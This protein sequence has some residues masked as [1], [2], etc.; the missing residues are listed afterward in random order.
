MRWYRKTV[1]P[2]QRPALSRGAIDH[3]GA[4]GSSAWFGGNSLRLFTRQPLVR[5]SGTNVPA[6]T[7]L[8]NSMSA[9]M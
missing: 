2:Y 7:S 3:S 1:W 6:S 9:R 8:R 5:G 4:D